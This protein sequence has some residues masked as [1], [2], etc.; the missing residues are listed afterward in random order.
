MT[1]PPRVLR[2][3]QQMRQHLDAFDWSGLTPGRRNI[4]EA[5]LR[6]AARQGY[7]AVTMRALGKEIH[8][9]AP[10]IYS[11]FPG[12]RD[13]IVA[14]SLRWDY[15]RFGLAALEAVADCK[16]G[17]EFFDAMVRIQLTH[18][19]DRPESDLWDIVV[20][21]D[22]IGGGFLQR[23]I[24]EEMDH[25]LRLC[26]R[27]YETA[28]QEMGYDNVEAKVRVVMTIL[29]G[30][31]SW[32]GWSGNPKDLEACAE[33]AIAITRSMLSLQV[34][35]SSGSLKKSRAAAGRS[36]RSTNS[37]RPVASP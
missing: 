27:M 3:S 25:W 23:D 7:A 31:S 1:L 6:L 24:R 21:S 33:Q 9:K 10:S 35:E 37:G 14:E 19:L 36:S 8:L 5:F 2:A 29:N 11:H 12:G 32:C 18:Q 26:A 22:R 28:A 17:S 15:Y 20:A 13:E 34:K 4:L 16:D 30:A